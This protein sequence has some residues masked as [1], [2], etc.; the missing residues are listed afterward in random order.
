MQMAKSLLCRVIVANFALGS[1]P[2]LAKDEGHMLKG[3]PKKKL[4][5]FSSA[6]SL[7]KFKFLGCF[8]FLEQGLTNQFCLNLTLFKQLESS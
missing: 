8:E 4:P 2:R 7:W 1:Q 6:P 5:R 3:N